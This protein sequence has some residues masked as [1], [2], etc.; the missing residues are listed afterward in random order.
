MSTNI[1]LPEA[2]KKDEFSGRV[3]YGWPVIIV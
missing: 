2:A 1:G 3:K